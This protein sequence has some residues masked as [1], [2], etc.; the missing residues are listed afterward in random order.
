MPKDEGALVYNMLPQS[1]RITLKQFNLVMEKGNIFHSPLF[2]VRVLKNQQE[3]RIASV[4][5]QKVVKLTVFRNKIRRK[6]YEA[7]RQIKE[8]ISN[9]NYIVVFAK[10]NLCKHSQKDILNDLKTLFVKAGVL[11]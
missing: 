11:G 7:L 9:G 10:V 3:T 5:P 2:W 4:A 8:S 6:T 1:S